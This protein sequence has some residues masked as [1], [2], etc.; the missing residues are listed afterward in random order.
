MYKGMYVCGI[1]YNV[2]CFV[3]MPCMLGLGMVWCDIL[4]CTWFRYGMTRGGMIT[5][6]DSSSILSDGYSV[7]RW[8]SLSANLQR[9]QQPADLSDGRRPLPKGPSEASE[10]QPLRLYLNSFIHLLFH[11]LLFLLSS[12]H[13]GSSYFSCFHSPFIVLY[14][15]LLF[16]FFLLFLLCFHFHLLLFHLFFLLHLFIHPS[17]VYLFL[18]LLSLIF[19]LQIFPFLSSSSFSVSCFL[20]YLSSFS[21]FISSSILHK[22]SSSS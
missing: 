4:Y 20:S 7:S 11:F 2:V 16:V 21:F 15:L 6:S 14:F 18:F 8:M 17:P 3:T 13:S 5:G 1:N 19:L 12:L 10:P 9:F 22:T